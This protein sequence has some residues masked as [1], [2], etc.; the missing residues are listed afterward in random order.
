[1]LVAL[2]VAVAGGDATDVRPGRLLAWAVFCAVS[3]VLP[4]PAVRN[5]YLS[6]S[7]PVNVAIAWL[8]PPG[9]GA[10][11]VFLASVSEWEVKGETTFA[12]AIY[13]RAQLAASTLAGSLALSVDGPVMVRAVL[14]VVAYQGCNWLLVGL[15]EHT[16]RGARLGAVVRGLL[17]N[18]PIAA[19][20]YLALGLMGIALALT[21]ERVGAWAV[22]LLMLPLLGARHAVHASRQL[23]DAEAAQRA[24]TDRLI[25]ERE[26]ERV[27]IA[28]DIHDVVL[29][30]LAALQLQSDNIVTALDRDQADLARRLAEHV[31]A[32]VGS[33]IAELRGSIANLR[34]LV[35]ESGGLGP[36]I[37][38]IARAFSSQSGIRVTVEV[39]PH[40][41]E[42]LGRPLALLLVECCQE[43]LVNVARHAR[44]RNV[45]VTVARDGEVVELLIVD[46][47]VGL[48]ATLQTEGSGLS[49]MQTKVALA[50]G[51]FRIHG[52]P[53]P[54]WGT[55][56]SV[57]VPA[58]AM[59]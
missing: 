11:L 41:D 56:V 49:L 48:P 15:A 2:G 30:Q 35:L 3:N 5:V 55:L 12:H 54:D 17:P 47:G 6:M 27:R 9:I 23:E 43:A 14:A 1:M 7:S 26:R 32:G 28:S 36:T 4:V 21:Y 29:Q 37:E 42:G 52:A 50:G 53:D 20:S 46:D 51:R 58:R 39:T 13:N 40:C 44:A 24:L 33:T 57:T 10:A 45:R 59:R 19:V 34:H 8:L 18:A 22:A 25:D 38:R 16:A 31:H